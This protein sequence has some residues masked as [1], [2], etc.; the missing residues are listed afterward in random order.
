MK[1]I[2]FKKIETK[3]NC[4]IPKD[5]KSFFT[6]YQ[7]KELGLRLCDEKTMLNFEN[8]LQNIDVNIEEQL[9]PILDDDNSNYAAIYLNG[10]LEGMICIID[11]EEPDTSPDFI[12]IWNLL[13]SIKNSKEIVQDE[14]IDFSN[15]ET[16]FPLFGDLTSNNELLEIKNKLIAKFNSCSDLKT[17]KDVAFKILKIANIEDYEFI[18]RNLLINEDVWIQEEVIN[19]IKKNLT[20]NYVEDI[21]EILEKNKNNPLIATAIL[22]RDNDNLNSFWKNEFKRKFPEIANFYL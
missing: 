20:E 14:F 10:E 18:K 6:L 3:I 2:E 17:K 11:H 19:T 8:I 9:L 4:K 15:L 1:Q 5:V 22:L 13:D 16:E 7:F 12:S 21:F